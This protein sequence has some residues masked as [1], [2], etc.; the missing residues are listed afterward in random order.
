MERD[1]LHINGSKPLLTLVAGLFGLIS[2][3]FIPA[4]LAFVWLGRLQEQVESNVRA[5]A[6]LQGEHQLMRGT[7]GIVESRQGD[8]RERLTIVE[9][10]LRA[11]ELLDDR[12]YIQ[13]ET[14]D[15]G[16]DPPNVRR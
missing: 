15:S 1:S 7:L 12:R 3:V 16:D 2:A 6:I 8:V 4:A 5:I 9:R 11:H 10:E 13:R 14:Q